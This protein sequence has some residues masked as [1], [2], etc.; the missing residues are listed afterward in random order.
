M[1]GVWLNYW[2]LKRIGA[3]KLLSMELIEPLIAV[4]LGSA[5]LAERLTLKTMIGGACILLA[6]SVVLDI[7]GKAD[8]RRP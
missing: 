5:F 4:L 7:F 1:A 8:E 3:T 2:L 6:V